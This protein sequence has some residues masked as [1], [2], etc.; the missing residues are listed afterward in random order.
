MKKIVLTRMSPLAL[1]AMLFLVAFCFIAPAAAVPQAD[2]SL[3]GTLWKAEDYP[4]NNGRYFRFLDTQAPKPW[5]VEP[6]L[7]VIIYDYDTVIRGNI[8]Q[9]KGNQFFIST[10]EGIRY[11]GNVADSTTIAGVY[12]NR[13]PGSAGQVR[14]FKLTRVS[15]PEI[16]ARYQNMDR[17]EIAKLLQ[18]KEKL[19]LEREWNLDKDDFS[20]EKTLWKYQSAD[21]DDGMKYWNMSKG[22]RYGSSKPGQ[23]LFVYNGYN[24]VESGFT[25]LQEGSKVFFSTRWHDY[26]GELV[27][28]GTIKGTYRSNGTANGKTSDFKLFRITDPE[29]LAR[30]A[31][32]YRP[33]PVPPN[34]RY[35]I[36]IDNPNEYSVSVTIKNITGAGSPWTGMETTWNVPPRAK[37]YTKVPDGRYEIYFIFSNQPKAKYQGDHFS[38]SG[39]GVTIRLVR[40]SDGNYGIRQVK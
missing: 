17:P 16:L 6:W 40:V 38:I 15:D 27:D 3:A 24:E 9:V 13:S 8:W 19:K 31:D 20:L 12:Q 39:N 35:A 34:H 2:L 18:E 33:K 32:A 7:E 29:I 21:G 10:V 22:R 1:L 36:Y 28:W 37:G 4:D 26:E 11:E 30:Y 23:E 25:W 14:N 5:N